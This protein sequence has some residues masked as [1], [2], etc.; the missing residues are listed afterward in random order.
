MEDPALPEEAHIARVMTQF[1]RAITRFRGS[2]YYPDMQTDGHLFEQVRCALADSLLC[3]DEPPAMHKLPID[4][5]SGVI[6]LLF[7]DGG[8]RGN[9]GP[10]GSGSVIVQLNVQAHAACVLWIS[11]MAHSAA[12]TT[13]NAAEYCG[14]VHGL[15]QAKASRYAPLHVVGDSAMVLSQL[16]THHPPRKPS[17][18]PLLRA[19]RAMADDISVSSWGHHYRPYNK[20]AD[21]LANIAMDTKDSIQ[22]MLLAGPGLFWK[23]RPSLTTMSTTGWRHHTRNY[24]TYR[25]P[26]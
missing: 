4:R 5:C 9:P 26:R 7:F 2:T 20:M 23:I 12:D 10:G 1:R 17:L 15:R 6:Y 18:R 3:A 22:P 25:V 11:S 16:R 21:R 8:S 19:A 14:L 13:N 24:K